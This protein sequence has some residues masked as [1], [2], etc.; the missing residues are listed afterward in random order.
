MCA[1]GCKGSGVTDMSV[2]V[3]D[4]SV[5]VSDSTED[6]ASMASSRKGT[7]PD[8]HPDMPIG[9][10]VNKRID[11]RTGKALPDITPDSSIHGGEDESE[12]S[13]MPPYGKEDGDH[14]DG[15]AGGGGIPQLHDLPDGGRGGDGDVFKGDSARGDKVSDEDKANWM[16]LSSRL[17]G[18]DS[19]NFR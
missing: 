6:E 4:M 11:P 19:L 9:K 15:G 16:P 5:V 18:V 17:E 14:D 1:C 12:L 10:G 8:E 13:D 2:V 7:P 3:T